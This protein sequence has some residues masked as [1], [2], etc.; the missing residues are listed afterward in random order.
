MGLWAKASQQRLRMLRLSRTRAKPKPS[1]APTAASSSFVIPSLDG[2]RA[3]AVGLVFMAHAGINGSPGPLGVTIFFFLSGYLITTL[4]R[5]E[6]EK[7]GAIS[8]RNFYLRR[9]FRILPPLYLVLAAAYALTILGV[10]GAQKLRLGACLAQVFFLSNYQILSSGWAGPHTGRPPGTGSLWSLAVEEHFYLLFPL[11]YLILCRLVHS[12]RRQA[13][14][15]A[16]ACGLILVWRF[17][18]ILGLHRSFDR[19]YAATDTRFDSIL[20]G[21]ILAIVGNPVL[22]WKERSRAKWSTLK[23]VWAPA[24]APLSVVAILGVYWLHDRR[25]TGT[26]QYTIDGLALIPLFIVAVRFPRWGVF[27]LLNIRPVMFVGAVSYSIYILH[28][29]VI[30]GVHHQVGGGQAVHGVLYLLI[31]LLIAWAMYRWVERPFARLRRRL[32]KV[33]AKDAASAAT[34]PAVPDARLAERR[35]VAPIPALAPTD[36]ST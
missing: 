17:V 4:L 9:A 3:L 8:L 5:M 34:E 22:D 32:S 19:T 6:F 33:G 29:I 35:S 15:L 31:T 24:L 12:R 13:M 2:I 18:L 10:L 7:T 36:G 21:C 30:A 11:C 16:G 1:S 14:Y 20:F 26:I 25:I 28:E 23:R 27:R